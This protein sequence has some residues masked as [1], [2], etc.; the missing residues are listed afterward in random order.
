MSGPLA[1]ASASVAILRQ[2]GHGRA[3]TWLSRSTPKRITADV[4]D[5]DTW[6]AL[7]DTAPCV[8][9]SSIWNQM[10]FLSRLR[11]VMSAVQ[12]SSIYGIAHWLPQRLPRF[13]WKVPA[14]FI[15]QGAIYGSLT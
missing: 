10:R 3:A 7:P 4:A 2:K 14:D 5:A 12:T 1:T 9:A 6:K 15:S 13:T 8:G 11:R